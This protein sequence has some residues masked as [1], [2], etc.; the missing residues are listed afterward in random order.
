MAAAVAW[1]Q[2]VPPAPRISGRACAQVDVVVVVSMGYYG[3][4]SAVVIKRS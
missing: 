1:I 4:V 2:G 3:N